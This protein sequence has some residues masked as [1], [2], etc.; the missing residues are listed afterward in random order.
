MGYKLLT[1]IFFC[2]LTVGAN[3]KF[4][5]IDRLIEKVKVQRH[6][7]TKEQIAKLKNPFIDQRTLKKIVIKQ[8]IIK[9][10]KRR[11]SFR[12]LSIF[13]NRA[14]I[15]GHWYKLGAK[16]GKYRLTYI[17]PNRA[18]VIL[19]AKGKQLRLFLHRHKHSLLKITDGRKK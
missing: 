13:D 18:F 17:D 11:F 15:N 12:L 16:I 9:H 14:K 19:S 1:V 4:E 2:A 10:K 6:G 8:K 5:D 3:S 7:L